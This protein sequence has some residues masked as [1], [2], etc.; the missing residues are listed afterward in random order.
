MI[1]EVELLR[2][3][4]P[5]VRY[6]QGEMFLPCPVE[7]YVER[8][9]LWLRLPGE[10]ARE[11]VP[12]GQL[13]LDSLVKHATDPRQR[14]LSMRFVERPLQGLEYQRWKPGRPPFKGVGRLA[15][16]GLGP[17]LLDAMFSLS[18]FLRG[19]VPGGTT[20]AAAVEYADI[21]QA[22]ERYPYYG[23]VVHAQGYIVLQYLFFYAMN[24]W[25]SSF[26]GVNDHEADW[27]QVFVYLEEGGDGEPRPLWLACAAHDYSG[28]DLRRRWD[29]PDLTIA[30]EHP[31]IFAGA[32]S[33]AAYF[34]PGEYL[35]AVEVTF[36]RPLL[37]AVRGF[38]RVWVEVLGQGDP[39]RLMQDVESL[40]RVP[41]VDYA[42]G[43]G[44]C[45][46]PDQPHEWSPELIDDSVGW[47]REYPGLWGLDTE[48]IFA[49]ELAPAG[50]RFD[51]SGAVRQSWY[52][53]LGWAGLSTV[54]PP[55]QV[56]ATIQQRIDE[57]A[58]KL[59]ATNRAT[60]ALA[61][62]ATKLD[63]QVRA[64]LHTA[65]TA[66]A[67]ATESRL[68]A[69][70]ARLDALRAREQE[71]ERT[72]E[73]MARFRCEVEAGDPGDPKAHLHNVRGPEPPQAARQSKVAELWA[74]V[75]VGL[76]MMAAAV[77]IMLDPGNVG[78]VLLLLVAGI[79]F[80][81]SILRR[82]IIGLLLN[83]TV[84]LAALTAVVLIVEFAWQ[85]AIVCMGAV[86]LVVLL[87]NVHKLRA[88]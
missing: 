26:S 71:M 70:T 30:G 43:D 61:E 24:D 79:V 25:R 75:S 72:I 64:A 66:E 52:D 46:G 78:S 38:R 48:D 67:R 29:D 7:R 39:A 85:L 22:D 4:E 11:L 47:V 18:L 82:T 9:S 63:L 69:V 23:R 20:A 27:E 84:C 34:Q 5:I 86:G 88:R 17:R 77:L 56:A 13:T 12:A 81:D 14:A 45:V 2:R 36:L 87:D 65:R 55:S 21:A 6:T 73:Q 58:A 60:S 54:A 76:F 15:R 83:F 41:F 35:T 33:H 49:G 28:A 42:R 37:R 57:L 8:C 74:A 1:P 40:I 32:G 3:Y 51:R 53:P 31:V 16:V 10:P 44:P 62:T 68:T 80:V 19:R 59:R 50:P